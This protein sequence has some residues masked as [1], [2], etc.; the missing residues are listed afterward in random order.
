MKKYDEAV[1]DLSLE[2]VKT[3][4]EKEDIEKLKM[5]GKFIYTCFEKKE[6]YKTIQESGK[7]E[8]EGEKFKE[9]WCCQYPSVHRPKGG[10]RGR[11]KGLTL[12][13]DVFFL[14]LT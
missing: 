1:G 11:R 3:V 12:Q 10:S 13:S 5:L 9:G 6:I 2:I 14:F 7:V 8:M 4:F